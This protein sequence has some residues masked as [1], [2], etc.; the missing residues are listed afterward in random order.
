MRVLTA[1]DV[2]EILKDVGPGSL[3]FLSYLAGKEPTERALLEAERTVREEGI[4]KRHVLGALSQVWESKKGDLCV[5][6]FADTRDTINK[7]GSKTRGA[8]RTYNP[9]LGQLLS[10]EVIHAVPKG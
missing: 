9:N 10:L 3:L 5:R 1:D 2:S 6:V 7:D 4:A 8:W